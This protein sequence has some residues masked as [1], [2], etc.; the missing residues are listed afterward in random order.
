MRTWTHL[1]QAVAVVACALV[2]GAAFGQLALAPGD[3]APDL[4]G[5]NYP[6]ESRFDADWNANHLTLVNFWA[7]WCQPCMDEAP[8]LEA[9]YRANHDR[10][11]MVIG[12]FE[13]WERDRVAP[14]LENVGVELTYPLIRPDA[15]VD[16]YWGGINL[17]PTS[18]LIDNSGRILRKYVGAKP[19]QTAGIGND[20][21]ALFEGKPMPAM[22]IP[23]ES[24][25]TEETEKEIN[26][27]KKGGGRR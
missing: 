13:R 18:F 19:E 26:K 9:L 1:G 8:A 16:H 12:V 25:L 17:K 21:H 11:L 3:P 2:A 15:T 10:G 4:G 6:V 14:F 24:F 22:V 23:T 7:T 5:S 27:H 20:I